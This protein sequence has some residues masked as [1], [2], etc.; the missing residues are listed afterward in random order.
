MYCIKCGKQFEGSFCPSCGTPAPEKRFCPKCG[1]EVTDP[2][3]KTCPVC[4][5][6]LPAVS[7][8][9]PAARQTAVQAPPTVVV[10]N[11]NQNQNVVSGVVHV[12]GKKCS[13]W[14]AF[15]LCLFLGFFGA[16]KFYEG[17]TGM[18]ILY[19]LT[20]GLLGIGWLIDLIVILTKP[21]PYY[22]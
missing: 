17:K 21:D 12:V 8:S 18:G 11:V 14:T 5:T 16:H 3:A 4:G 15:F 6:A 20:A 9:A 22:V 1:A 2:A 13:K 19:L 10:N 7:A